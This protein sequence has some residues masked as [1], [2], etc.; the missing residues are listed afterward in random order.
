MKELNDGIL[1]VCFID[2]IPEIVQEYLKRKLCDIKNIELIL[3]GENNKRNL[4][5]IVSDATIKT[6]LF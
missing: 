5:K 2:D 1:K 4:L 6:K 3:F